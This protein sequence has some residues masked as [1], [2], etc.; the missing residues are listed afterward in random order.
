MTPT[1]GQGL[2]QVHGIGCQQPQTQLRVTVTVLSSTWTAGEGTYRIYGLGVMLQHLQVAAVVRWALR[3][4]REQ[5][6]HER[7]HSLVA[8]GEGLL[9]G[10]EEQEAQRE[11][12]GDVMAVQQAAGRGAVARQEARLL[13][14]LQPPPQPCTNETLPSQR[15][16]GSPLNIM[17]VNTG[18]RKACKLAS[19]PKGQSVPSCAGSAA[20]LDRSTHR[21]G[22]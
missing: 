20:G 19:V 16:H 22:S 10:A 18:Q 3:K 21:A 17:L 14:G 9:A 4:A 6:H 5:R 11:A 1:G 12:D 7:R 8:G 13:G 15:T 2:A